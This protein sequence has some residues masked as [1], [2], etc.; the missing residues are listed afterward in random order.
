M[1]FVLTSVAWTVT[2][3][4]EHVVVLYN[5]RCALRRVKFELRSLVWPEPKVKPRALPW[6]EDEFQ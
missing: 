6:R 3:K 4:R 5:C 2:P 1:W